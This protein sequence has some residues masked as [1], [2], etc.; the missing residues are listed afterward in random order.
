MPG[1]LGSALMGRLIYLRV[2]LGNKLATAAHGHPGSQVLFPCFCL[3]F[4]FADT[5]RCT[6][7]A[8]DG[9]FTYATLE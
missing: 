3:C 6:H 4:V 5:R 9:V 2:G 8:G 1:S 7:R